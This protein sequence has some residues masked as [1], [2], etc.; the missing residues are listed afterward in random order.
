MCQKCEFGVDL[1][2][3]LRWQCQRGREGAKK[4]ENWGDVI[5]GWP[6]MYIVVVLPANFMARERFICR[7]NFFVLF[8]ISTAANE[9]R[10]M[11]LYTHYSILQNSILCVCIQK[12]FSYRIENI[13]IHLVF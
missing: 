8:N 2:A 10:E 12:T 5:Y 1:K 9:L 3:T 11:Q 13:Q 4:L 6:L 7:T